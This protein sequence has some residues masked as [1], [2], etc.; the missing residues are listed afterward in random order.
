MEIH[1]MFANS[2]NVLTLEKNQKFYA[3]TLAWAT[4]ID[5]DRFIMC[6]GGQ[7]D[8]GRQLQVGDKIG[9][10]VLSPEE[11]KEAFKI[12]ATHSTQTNKKEMADFELL[13]GVYVVK[14]AKNQLVGEVIKIDHYPE[15]IEDSIVQV[16]VL[17]AKINKEKDFLIYKS[18]N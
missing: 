5:F 15:A 12:G 6:V 17:D 3:M 4:Q 1:A 8:T 14:G 11:E 16:K 13:N 2:V 9:L 7:A 18:N 10:S